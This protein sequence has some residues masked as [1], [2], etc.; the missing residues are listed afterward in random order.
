V[1]ADFLRLLEDDGP[2]PVLAVGGAT[3]DPPLVVV[4]ATPAAAGGGGKGGGVEGGS[5]EE[6][7]VASGGEEEEEEEEE[8]EAWPRRKRQAL[9]FILLRLP[10]E[11]RMT[12]ARLRHS[13]DMPSAARWSWLVRIRFCRSDEKLPACRG[14]Q[15]S[16][17]HQGPSEVRGHQ[18]SGVTRGN[19]PP[20]SGPIVH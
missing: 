6:R 18:G 9:P 11:L 15:G 7:P 5:S 20:Q 2:G 16:G 10:M 17:G 14:Y 3:D 1:C 4:T 8:Q 13:L 19:A 12:V